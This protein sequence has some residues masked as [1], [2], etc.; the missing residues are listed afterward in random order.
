MFLGPL[1]QSKPW[2][3]NGID[4]V[5]KFLRK[6]WRLFHDRN[7]N[8]RVTEEKATEQ[9]LKILHKTIKKVEEDI[10]KYSFNTSVSSFMICV[11]ELASLNCRKREILAPLTIIISPY[12]PHITEELWSLLGY[13]DSINTAT[14][15]V[16]DE[17]Y[18]QEDT[19]EYP[20]SINGKLRTKI[21]F[22]LD[23]PKEDMEREILAS[24][25]VQKWLQ[26]KDP[27]KIIIVPHKIVNVVV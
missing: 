14:F 21:T 3:T 20:V 2:N 25:V 18:I 17:K 12:A 5:S 26:G 16:Y 11:N 23:M 27:K 7:N 13:E 10:N 15:P 4:G 8:F 19:F 22:N 24:E 6:F 1:E 9:E